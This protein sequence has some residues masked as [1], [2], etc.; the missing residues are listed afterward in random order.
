MSAI[1]FLFYTTAKA[2]VYAAEGFT[3]N[4]GW[5]P[6][7]DGRGTWSILWSCLA[8]ISFAHGHLNT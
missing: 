5:V 1:V 6:E 8:T 2:H 3:M 4:H 7:P